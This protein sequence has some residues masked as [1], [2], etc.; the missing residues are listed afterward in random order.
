VAPA[1]PTEPTART[2]VTPEPVA[3]LG[4][5]VG[6]PQEFLTK[7]WGRAPLLRAPQDASA[8]DDLASLDDFDRMVASLGLQAPNLRMVRDGKPLSVTAYTNKPGSNSRGTDPIVSGQKVYENFRDGATIV[9]ESLHKYWQ[10]LSDFCRD[11]E[12][13]LGHRLQVNAYITPPGSQGFDVHRDS[14]DVFVLQVSGSKHWTV[15]D[16]YEDDVVLIDQPIKRGAA[17]YIP[18]GFPHAAKSGTAASAHLTVGILT[19]ESIEITR[20]LVKLAEQEP[21]F[22]ER[23]PVG[24][25]H[26][27][28]KLRALV[29]GHLDEMRSWLDK[30]DVDELTQRVARKL[31]SSSQPIVRSQLR[32]FEALD[33]I[34][35]DTELARRRGAVCLLFPTDTSLKVMLVDR[36]LE[37]PLGIKPAMELIA[38]RERLQ[39]R[40]LHDHLVPDSALVLVKRLVREGLLEVVVDR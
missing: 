11:L 2:S 32:Q 34:D 17:L 14:H 37:M 23:L 33:S 24:A 4:R 10:P 22:K 29:E 15:Y 31:T 38:T 19:H 20:Q 3:A 8:F 26:D 18:T 39:P 28:A 13:A 12:L 30:V 36:E 25:A 5:C 35:A 1:T 40:E 16:R 21:A 7:H 9:L 6:D 27:I